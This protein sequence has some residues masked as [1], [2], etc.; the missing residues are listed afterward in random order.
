MIDLMN[1]DAWHVYS[2]GWLP[3]TYD[4]QPTFRNTGS[5][6]Y[7]RAVA[8]RNLQAPRSFQGWFLWMGSKYATPPDYAGIHFH[9]GHQ[10]NGFN[11]AMSLRLDGTAVIQ[12]EYD[13]QYTKLAVPVP[14]MLKGWRRY[15]FECVWGELLEFRVD[16]VTV[17]RED[18]G[19][20]WRFPRVA[21]GQVGFRLDRQHVRL[22]SLTVE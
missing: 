4:G 13:G 8:R 9:V 5:Y 21:S 11:Y 16:G 19:A 15:Q 2:G 3:E 14:F 17:V 1:P 22:G 7:T 6:N 18:A 20:H 10:S 12:Q